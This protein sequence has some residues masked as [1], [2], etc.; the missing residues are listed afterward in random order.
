ML[1]AGFM[2]GIDLTS[3]G[4]ENCILIAVT[5]KRTKAEIDAYV[6][7]IKKAGEAK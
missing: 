2:P 7:Y 4:L 3:F 5:E 1:G 6:E